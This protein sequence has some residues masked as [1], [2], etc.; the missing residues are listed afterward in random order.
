MKAQHIYEFTD[1][2]P[3]K[4]YDDWLASGSDTTEDMFFNH[5]YTE[6]KGSCVY[7]AISEAVSHFSGHLE[8]IDLQ[9]LAIL[10]GLTAAE[11]ESL[12]GRDKLKIGGAISLEV[13]QALLAQHGVII[14]RAY[15]HE[16]HSL[17]RGNY[18]NADKFNFPVESLYELNDE[19]MQKAGFIVSTRQDIN[20]GHIEFAANPQKWFDWL[21]FLSASK[22]RIDEILI[23]EKTE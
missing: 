4:S 7:T 6:G 11:F 16:R 8:R 9:E 19:V 14:S 20:V 5:V 18:P 21:H 22:H 23:L 10:A 13:E 12:Y 2:G 17:Y 3:R 1:L 15:L